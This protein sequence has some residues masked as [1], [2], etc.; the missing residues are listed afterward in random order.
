M[1]KID[2]ARD[3]QAS[4]PRSMYLVHMYSV[5]IENDAFPSPVCC[6]FFFNCLVSFAAR[7]T[8]SY[9]TIHGRVMR[10]VHSLS[11]NTR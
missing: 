10:W 5:Y 11:Q 2:K 8:A 7:S 9:I 3:E 4:R 6:L 1:V